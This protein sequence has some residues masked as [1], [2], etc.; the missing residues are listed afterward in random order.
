MGAWLSLQWNHMNNGI[1]KII[2]YGIGALVVFSLLEKMLP[3]IV[4]F[5]ALIGGYFIYKEYQSNNRR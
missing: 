5:L 4:F 1:G 3:T 2:L